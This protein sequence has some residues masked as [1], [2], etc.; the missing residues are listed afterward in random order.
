MEIHDQV[1]ITSDNRTGD[2]IDLSK[3]HSNL[4]IL[5]NSEFKRKLAASMAFPIRRPIDYKGLTRTYT[6]PADQTK[7]AV[8]V[9]I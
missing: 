4:R 3:V 9:V 8:K 1:M 5:L 6:I 2:A 7:W